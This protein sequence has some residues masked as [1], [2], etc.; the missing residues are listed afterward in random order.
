MKKLLIGGAALAL[1]VPVLAQV[2]PAPAP[3]PAPHGRMDQKVQT[4]AGIEAK[5]ARHF[6]QLDTNH[7]G[8]LTQ[9]EADAGMQALQARL[10]GGHREHHPSFEQLDANRDGAISRSEWNANEAQRE[11]RIAGRDR[12]H[13]GQPDMH[14]MGGPGGAQ[15]FGGQMFALADANHDGRVTLQEAQAAML[16]HFDMVDLNHDGRITPEER[17]QMHERMRGAGR[18]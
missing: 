9:A 16:R 18:G 12:K 4:R 5:V 1:A 11:Q 3:A 17:M 7:D 2:A 8:F 14:R 6:A 15:R 10:M 13:D